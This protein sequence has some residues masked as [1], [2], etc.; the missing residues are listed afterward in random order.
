L[1]GRTL[2]VDLNDMVRQVMGGQMSFSNRVENEHVKVTGI[3][4]HGSQGKVLAGVWKGVKVRR[5]TDGT[6]LASPLIHTSAAHN[7][8]YTRIHIA[9]LPPSIHTVFIS[10]LLVYLLVCKQY[11]K[12]S[13]LRQ[14]SD[15]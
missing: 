3:L 13:T 12:T 6:G 14:C 15:T 8:Y 11:L 10:L 4:G 2:A 1:A 9:F 5:P 7:N